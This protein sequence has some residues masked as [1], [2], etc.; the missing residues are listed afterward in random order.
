MTWV[1]EGLGEVRGLLPGDRILPLGGTGHRRVSRVLMEGRVPRS[2]RRSFPLLTRGDNV[3][4]L[5]GVCRSKVAV[6]D[7]GQTAIRLEVIPGGER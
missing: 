6:P 3:I 2:E 1:T 4:W 7:T 5:P